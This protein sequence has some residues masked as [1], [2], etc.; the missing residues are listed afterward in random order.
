MSN[1][2]TE[3]PVAFYIMDLDTGCFL[4]NFIEQFTL[5]IY[6]WPH[7]VFVCCAWAFSSCSEQGLL[8]TAIHR[9]L[10]VASRG[11]FSWGAQALGVRALVCAVCRL[12]SCGAQ[13]LL[14]LGM[15]NLLGP[16]IEPVPPALAD[17]FLSIVPP[18]KSWTIVIF[19]HQVVS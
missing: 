14:L 16:R 18:G 9:L 13:A 3:T 4:L 6:F 10:V 5:F 11:G 8:F 19:T 17:G 1:T 7:W 15:W 12:S 2:E